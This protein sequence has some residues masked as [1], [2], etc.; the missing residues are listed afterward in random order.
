MLVI[1]VPRVIRRVLKPSPRQHASESL[2]ASVI[3]TPSKPASSACLVHSMMLERGLSG[4]I[5]N[6]RAIFA[7]VLLMCASRIL[8]LAER[9][10]KF[11]SRHSTLRGVGLAF[12]SGLGKRLQLVAFL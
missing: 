7:I 10:H 5:E 1:A 4:I 3:K 6:A 9:N 11:D 8:H 2:F 12:G